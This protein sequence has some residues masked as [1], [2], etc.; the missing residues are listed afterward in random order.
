[1][2]EYDTRIPGFRIRY[3]TIA[4]TSLI[5]RMICQLAAYEHL[6]QE[7]TATEDT[8]RE[9][10]FDRGQAQVLIGE[11]HG[12]PVGFALFFHSFSTFLGKANLYLED[13]Y[14]DP[15]VRGKGLGRAMF[16]CLAGIA[17]EE[18]C[19]RLDWWCL[20]ENRSAI[21]FYRHM[22]AQAMS[23][24]TVYRLDGAALQALSDQR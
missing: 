13:L 1:M 3:A 5:L 14:L 7:V 17:I 4:D 11:L 16:T 12:K 2:R 15:E 23:D 6:E 22:G 24:W 21:A 9:S 8:L 10:L 19:G 18:G 20:D